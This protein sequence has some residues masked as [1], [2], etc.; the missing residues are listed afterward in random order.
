MPQIGKMFFTVLAI[1]A[2][3]EREIT[4]ERTEVVLELE[5]KMKGG[6]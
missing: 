3:F 4:S 6:R 1:L 2:Q 5:V